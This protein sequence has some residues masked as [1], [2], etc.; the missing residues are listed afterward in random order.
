MDRRGFTLIEL[1]L[2]V[3]IIGILATIAIPKFAV[4]RS[5]T[6]IA[7]MEADLRNLSIHQEIYHSAFNTYAPD[8]ESIDDLEI[9]GG[10]D[11]T[12]NA[13]DNR[14]WA[15]TAEHRGLPGTECGLFVGVANASDAGPATAEN[16]VACAP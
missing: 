8:V 15:A 5:K 9:S 1:L 4:V 10:V 6:M 7:A 16:Q 3:V 2:V 12:I 11:V 13:A 14:G